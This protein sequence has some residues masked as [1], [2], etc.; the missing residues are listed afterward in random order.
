VRSRAAAAAWAGLAAVL[1]GCGLQIQSADL[2]ALTRT[3]PNG[4][5]TLLVSDGGTVTCNGGKPK[6]ISDSRLIQAR[7]LADELGKDAK[8]HLTLP[9]STRSVNTYKVRLQQGTLRFADT[10]AP[11]RKELAEA[12]LFTA[13]TATEVCG[14]SG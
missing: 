10:D 13:Q 5:L 11:G 12:E 8:R 1:A 4:R 7:D 3:G 14:L 2:F 6:P 9:V